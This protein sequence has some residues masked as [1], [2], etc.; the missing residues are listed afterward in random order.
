MSDNFPTGVDLKPL[1]ACGNA[2]FIS[3]LDRASLARKV[4]TERKKE[5]VYSQHRD[6]FS[7]SAVRHIS[8]SLF[9]PL[10]SSHFPRDLPLSFSRLRL[11]CRTHVHRGLSTLCSPP[12]RS[13]VFFDLSRPPSLQAPLFALFPYLSLSCSAARSSTTRSFLA[14]SLALCIFH[15]YFYYYYNYYY[16]LLLLLPL[17][18]RLL[19]RSLLLISL[20]ST[21]QGPFSRRSLL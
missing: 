19:L 12:P 13:E 5:G 6:T 15:F 7:L 16:N 4:T 21:S 8:L 11:G 1:H 10:S 3:R 17:L 9:S 2:S 18:L 14:L 20:V